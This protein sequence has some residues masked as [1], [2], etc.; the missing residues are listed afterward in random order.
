MR[1]LAVALPLLIV[2]VALAHAATTETVTASGTSFTPKNVGL[3]VGDTV[4]WKGG[5]GTHN[6]VFDDG[7]YTSGA[8]TSQ[9]KIGER[10]FDT[11]GTFGYHCEVHGATGGIGMSGTIV[12]GEGGV[13]NP[14]PTATPTEVPTSGELALSGI[15]VTH[16]L[17]GGRLR[18]TLQASPDGAGLTIAV[19]RNENTVGKRTVTTHG[20]VSFSVKLARSVRRAVGRGKRP[21]IRVDFTLK[22]DG[23]RVTARRALRLRD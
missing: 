16:T 14:D 4:A 15:T 23:E 11:A 18:G 6:V 7:S 2:P 20:A 17:G 3:S 13:T 5:G 8:P 1:R 12:V 21:K 19:T 9:E 10:T 22:A